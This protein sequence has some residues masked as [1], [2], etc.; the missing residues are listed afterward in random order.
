MFV[1]TA[2]L[3]CSKSLLLCE[4]K[5]ISIIAIIIMELQREI[6]GKYESYTISEKKAILEETKI[7]STRE[8][9]RKYCMNEATI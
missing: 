6:R 2:L 5:Q 3:L 8:V 1:C 7:P 9:A 4:C